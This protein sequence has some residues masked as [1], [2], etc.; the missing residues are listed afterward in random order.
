MQL[1]P[2]G[3]AAIVREEGFR[4]SWYRCPAGKKTIGI[5]HVI[6]PA[7]EKVYCAPGFKLTQLQG[8]ALLQK[9]VSERFA[10]P[11]VKLCTRA[12]LPNQL[13]ALVSFCFNTGPGGLQQS[14][15]LQLHNAGTASAEEITEAFG[16]W[17]KFTDPET[18]KLVVSNGLTLRR[19]REAALYL[20]P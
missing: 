4:A 7:E 3:L 11:V 2:Q 12:C 5:G 14:H 9:D 16:R 15:L 1:T 10:P 19:A 8:M 6:L 17:N 13:A 20:T 18:G